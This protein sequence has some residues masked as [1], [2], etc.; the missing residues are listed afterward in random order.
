MK[1]Y[2]LRGFVALILLPALLLLSACG[3]VGETLNTAIEV[4][5]AVAAVSEAIDA[6]DDAAQES[7]PEPATTANAPPAKTEAPQK[8]EA[9]EKTAQPETTKEP[10]QT[11]APEPTATQPAKT[12]PAIDEFGSYTTA[13]DVALY[14]HTY[15]RLPDNFMTKSE[16]RDL[17][18]EGGS[19]EKYAPGMCIGGDRFGNYEGNLPK[20]N[21]TECD[22]DTLGASSRGAKRI[23]FS[24]DGRIYYTEDHYSTFTQL[25]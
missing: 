10:E 14:I 19:L 24:D 23:V 9:P 25:Y 20:G 6:A 4:L 2:L 13:Q 21:Y 11:Q 5:D 17:G 7:L 15:G 1:K 22:I 12:E 18:W 3:D 8:T 16:A